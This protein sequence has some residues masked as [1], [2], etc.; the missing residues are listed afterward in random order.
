MTSCQL[1]L[2]SY[3]FQD[4]EIFLNFVLTILKKRRIFLRNLLKLE[5]KKME[6]KKKF[7]NVLWIWPQLRSETFRFYDNCRTT[8]RCIRQTRARRICEVQRIRVTERNSA[9]KDWRNTVYTRQSLSSHSLTA[10]AQRWRDLQI[11][12]SL[13]GAAEPKI[14]LTS[15]FLLKPCIWCDVFEKSISNTSHWDPKTNAGC[16]FSYI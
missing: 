11:W 9:E 15:M 12:L 7:L 13:Q 8:E 4:F 2:R 6:L 16:R 1:S 5:N 14:R 10:S 3:S